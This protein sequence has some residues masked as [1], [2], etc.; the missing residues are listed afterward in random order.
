[1]STLST[2]SRPSK[3]PAPS[4]AT[5]PEVR[6]KRP[7][8]GTAALTTPVRKCD[9]AVISRAPTDNALHRQIAYHACVGYTADAEGEPTQSESK[10]LE[11]IERNFI[12]PLDFDQDKRRFGPL[13][14]LSRRSRLLNAYDN[15]MLERRVNAVAKCSAARAAEAKGSLDADELAHVCRNC[16]GNHLPRDCTSCFQAKI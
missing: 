13:A 8:A 10:A 9:P 4:V 14:G 3:R 12:V 7:H 6:K 11:C 5:S 1:M 16:A 15:G 2:P